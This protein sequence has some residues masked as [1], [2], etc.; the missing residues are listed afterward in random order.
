MLILDMGEMLKR[1]KTINQLLEEE[2]S[3]INY[4][5]QMEKLAEVIAGIQDS[6][7]RQA[8]IVNAIAD[9]IREMPE[10]Y[11]RERYLNYLKV[12]F[13]SLLK[14]WDMGDRKEK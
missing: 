7:E 13:G 10:G 12:R 8:E 3:R 2:E 14:P 11:W 1:I 6:P 9:E 4:Q 5:H